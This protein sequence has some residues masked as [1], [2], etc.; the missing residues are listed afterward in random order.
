MDDSGKIPVFGGNGINGY[1]SEFN[2][3]KATIVIGRVGAYCGSIHITDERAWVTDNA[4]ITYYSSLL[5]QDWLFY[6]LII[7]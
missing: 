2:V 4:F 1:H 6:L 5:N 7:S 3:Q